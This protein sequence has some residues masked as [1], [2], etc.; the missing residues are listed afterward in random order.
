MFNSLR[1]FQF[2]KKRL[3]IWVVFFLKK[4]SELVPEAHFEFVLLVL[5]EE[6]HVVRNPDHD[7]LTHV[8]LQ[9]NEHLMEHDEEHSPDVVVNPLVSVDAEDMSFLSDPLV[10]VIH[11]E[12]ADANRDHRNSAEK[13]VQFEEHAKLLL[14]QFLVEVKPIW[15]DRWQGVPVDHVVN[16]VHDE[17]KNLMS[18]DNSDDANE[19]DWVD[20]LITWLD[21]EGQHKQSPCADV[22]A[23]AVDSVC[24]VH[25]ARAVQV[26]L[27]VA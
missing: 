7:V 24:P 9:E 21:C 4:S 5:L 8:D 25:L 23:S 13:Q 2:G 1:F 26:G 22:H 14:C 18:E 15:G 11:D 6:S 16:F 20:V 10:R 3:H 19:D 12:E 27:R 17:V